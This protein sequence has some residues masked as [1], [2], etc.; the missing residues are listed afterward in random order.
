[1]N[2]ELARLPLTAGAHLRLAL[3]ALGLGL[4]LSLPLG[5]A[6][7]RNRRLAGWVV[8]SASVIQTLPSLALLALM[9]PVLAWLGS[10]SATHL[11]VRFSSIGFLPA[12]LALTLYSTLPILQNTIAGLAGVPEAL[13]E[14]ARGVGMT[15]GQALRKVELPTSMPIIVAGVRTAAVWVVGT[16]TLS[17]PVGAMSL[18]DHIFSGLQTRNF[19]AVIVGCLG[20][21]VLALWIDTTLRLL[22]SAFRTRARWRFALCAVLFSGLLGIAFAGRGTASLGEGSGPAVRIGAKTFSEQ[23]ILSECLSQWIE[24]ETGSPAPVRSSL[25]STLLFDALANGELDLYVDYSGTLWATILK[26]GPPPRGP[27]ARAQVLD[28]VSRELLER[29]GVRVAAALGFENTYA[30]AMPRSA[31]KTR[32]VMT[33]SE[34]AGIASEL[35]IGGDYE[36]FVR[37]EWEDLVAT[38]GFSF[39]KKRSMD[40]SLMYGAA[41]SGEV[42]VI[43]A[44][45]TDGR[46]AAFDLQV[47]DDD[48]RVIPP[49]DALVLVRD[50]F[51]RERRDLAA[52][53]EHLSGTISGEQMR[54]LNYEVDAEG[55]SPVAV[56]R[57]CA[58]QLLPRS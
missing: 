39:R 44:F 4:A 41:A 36:F 19:N 17:T 2:E 43:S 38:Y 45:S 9:V 8:G 27:G 6:A 58:E 16:A 50:S 29:H 49:Y 32:G 18:G 28:R 55:R 11:G 23:Y 26:A 20:A 1:M 42:D 24:R 14:A 48:R 34:L 40:S 3:F 31:A 10:Q 12:L 37:P 56:G 52:R 21:A 53:L 51:W 46:I 54:R 15:P 13:R 5:I 7:S 22:E 25:G 57:E 47:L 33:L 30:L 35:E